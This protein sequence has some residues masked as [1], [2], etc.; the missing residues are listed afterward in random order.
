VTPDL[1]DHWVLPSAARAKQLLLGEVALGLGLLTLAFVVL[2]A[3]VLVTVVGG[4]CFLGGLVAV[5]RVYQ[6]TR[7]DGT[8]HRD[9]LFRDTQWSTT[10]QLFARR[11]HRRA[12]ELVNLPPLI[13]PAVKAFA[14][15][16]APAVFVGAAALVIVRPG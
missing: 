14:L 7:V 2:G 16:V 15:G 4:A 9:E 10:T 12:A 8:R 5:V 11:T 3:G 1:D 13:G 6:E